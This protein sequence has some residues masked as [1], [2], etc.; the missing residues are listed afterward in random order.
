MDLICGTATG[1]LVVDQLLT[2]ATTICHLAKTTMVE[3]RSPI[4]I[5]QTE[6]TGEMD[7][8]QL[9]TAYISESWH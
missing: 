8:K 7:V 4:S 9:R 1:T 6:V 2:Q 3:D 5:C